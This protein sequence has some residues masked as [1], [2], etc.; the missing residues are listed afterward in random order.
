M[1]RGKIFTEADYTGEFNL[2]AL[3]RRIL[4]R[5]LKKTQCQYKAA[6]LIKCS[7]RAV[8][9]KILAHKISPSEWKDSETRKQLLQ[10][11]KQ[12]A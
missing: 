8:G 2:L 5:E 10:Q 1:C 3:E 7:D 11:K 4:I 6:K 9:D 12:A